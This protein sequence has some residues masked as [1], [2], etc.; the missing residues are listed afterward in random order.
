[1]ETA[2]KTAKKVGAEVQG[3]IC[4]TISPVHTIDQYVEL[5]KN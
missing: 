4:Y 1:M 3:A 2:I 5:A